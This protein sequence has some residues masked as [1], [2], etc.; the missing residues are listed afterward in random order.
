MA[1][2]ANRISGPSAIRHLMVTSEVYQRVV[3]DTVGVIQD[4]ATEAS[5]IEAMRSYAQLLTALA[6]VEQG[7]GWVVERSQ[8][9]LG[10]K[11]ETT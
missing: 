11:E 5:S 1:S 2:Q 8:I 10:E 7:L 6:G 9:L 3:A 4:A